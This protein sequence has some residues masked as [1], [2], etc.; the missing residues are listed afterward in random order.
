MSYFFVTTLQVF[1]CIALLSGVLWSR[2]DPP[3]LRPLVWTLFTGLILGV[4]VG[5]TLRGSQPVQLLLVGTEVMITLLFVLSF[6]WV[7]KRILYLWQGILVFGAARHWALD[8]N[9][10]GLT[11]THVLNTDLLLNLT[12]ML[13]AFAI[14][15][16]VGVLSAMLL[17]RIRGLYWP[18]TLILMVMIWL[19]L[20]GNLLLLLMKLQVL[21]LA[22]SL[23]SFVAKV[24]NNA[25]M[26]NWL[27]AALLL[28]LALCW[29]PALL[30]AIRQTRK[31]DEPIA[32][33]LALAHRRN[34]FR[35]WLFT[36]GCAVVVIAGQLW[37]EKVASQPPQLSEAIPVQLASDGMVHLPI[38][39]LRDGKL[40]RFVWVA[41]DGKAVRFF[42]INRYP[43][44][45]RLG[46]VFDACLLC[47]DQGYVMEGNQVICVACGVHIFIP[48]IGKP[49][50]CNPVPI[51][52]WRN[53]E[54]ELVIPGKEL[55][56]G[57][58]Y[59]STVMAIKVTDPVDGSTLTNTSADYKYSYGGKTW[60]FSSE[61]NYD[62]FRKTPEQFVPA[63]LREE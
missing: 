31:A 11:S 25:A 52:N 51:E 14:L 13:L 60:F 7:S 2:I 18:L 50:G 44:K 15:C 3:S 8:P 48:S 34:A 35:L 16:L 61:A 17:R 26:Y 57:V 1:F 58:N 19:P 46:V 23:L 36:L 55:A 9:L 30:R 39:R 38:E 53:D 28:A 4:L 56:A 40:H 5:L 21:P 20:S 42:V 24:T 22:R 43:D 10:G 41:D 33:R 54:K 12:A 62:R 27:G 32:Y 6:W 47:G 49:G 59:F 37:W 45:L 63:E 29:V